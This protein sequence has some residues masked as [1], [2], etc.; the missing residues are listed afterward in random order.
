MPILYFILLQFVNVVISTFKSVLT[1]KG[2]KA[3]AA[4]MNS[5]AYSVNIV[6]IYIVSGSISLWVSISVTFF[7]NMIGVYI[8]LSIL[9]KLRKD[10]LWRISTT[11]PT[12]SV[13]EFKKE[14]LINNI[15]FIAFETSWEDYKAIDIFSASRS[16]SSKISKLI[17]KYRVKYT[18]LE[19]SNTL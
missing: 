10:Q 14:L 12:E 5:I 4:I 17:G 1:I 15:K 7:V 2:S 13:Q 8:G 16:E 6:V 11:V 19:N 3:N 18:I 9:E